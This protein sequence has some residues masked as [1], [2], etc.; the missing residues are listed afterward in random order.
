MSAGSS[1]QHRLRCRLIEQTV[2]KVMLNHAANLLPGDIKRGQVRRS[3]V[4]PI[5]TAGNKDHSGIR[6]FHLPLSRVENSGIPD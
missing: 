3:N 1:Q 2:D 5:G 4:L 6:F